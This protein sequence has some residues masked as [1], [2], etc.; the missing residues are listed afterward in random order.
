ML[1]QVREEVDVQ[2]FS[3]HL[4]LAINGVEALGVLWQLLLNV[5][6]ADVDGL[7]SL[8]QLLHVLPGR[9]RGIHQTQLA[10]PRCHL[11]QEYLIALR[12]PQYYVT[13]RS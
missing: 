6:G 7:Q 8:P 4:E 10:L 3:S 5:L 13:R 11:G 12:A 1:V 9:Q 2:G